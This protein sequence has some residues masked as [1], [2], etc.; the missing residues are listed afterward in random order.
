MIGSH[1]DTQ[2][3]RQILQLRRIGFCV[4]SCGHW[5][6]IPKSYCVLLTTVIFLEKCIFANDSKNCVSGMVELLGEM[7]EI[8]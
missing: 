7:R 4:M 6:H 3:L 1:F 8:T 2:E 5:S